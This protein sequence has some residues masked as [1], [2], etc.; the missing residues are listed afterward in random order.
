MTH[1]RKSIL[2]EFG[3]V[4]GEWLGV[5]SFKLCVGQLKKKFMGYDHGQ[6]TRSHTQNCF[7]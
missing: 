2:V 7:E 4:A 5:D 6:P 3:K 1:I